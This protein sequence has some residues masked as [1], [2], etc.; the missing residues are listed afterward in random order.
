MRMKPVK[1][2][3]F[4]NRKSGELFV[5]GEMVVVV[6]TRPDANPFWRVVR[7]EIRE[8]TKRKAKR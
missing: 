4:A 3:A 2:W 6:A 8:V 7:V 1:A 5:R